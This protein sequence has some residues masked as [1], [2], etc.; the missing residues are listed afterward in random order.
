MRKSSLGSASGAGSSIGPYSRA[1][2]RRTST[3]RSDGGDAPSRMRPA[4]A[5]TTAIT[6]RVARKDFEV[7]GGDHSSKRRTAL[8]SSGSSFGSASAVRM[9]S[10]S[11]ASLRRTLAGA[12]ARVP[13]ASESSRPLAERIVSSATCPPWASI[14]VRRSSGSRATAVAP[15]GRTRYVSRNGSSGR[16]PR[17]TLGR[18]VS[19]IRLLWPL[20]LLDGGL[21]LFLFRLREEL[22]G[23]LA[24]RRRVELL[25]LVLDHSPVV[26]LVP[27]VERFEAEQ[28]GPADELA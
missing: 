1:T 20:S 18:V 5:A 16:R 9:P 6:A 24:L 13:I 10:P 12:S 25:R 26:V 11:R 14:T 19:A 23:E 17:T 3:S 28:D 2:V 21:R 4:G 15:P 7:P 8:V 27:V 22:V